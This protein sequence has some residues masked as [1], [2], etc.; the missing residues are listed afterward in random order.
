[1]RKVSKNRKIDYTPSV[2]AKELKEFVDNFDTKIEL[3]ETKKLFKQ[4]CSQQIN[5][6]KGA[7][8]VI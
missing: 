3:T 1:M 2:A 6:I 7:V 8:I 4:Y 5:K